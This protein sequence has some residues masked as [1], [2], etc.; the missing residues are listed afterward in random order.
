MT[1]PKPQAGDPEVVKI[2]VGVPGLNAQVPV[3]RSVLSRL[4][5]VFR[6]RSPEHLF[7]MH[8]GLAYVHV[9]EDDDGAIEVYLTV[10]NMGRRTANVEQVHVDGCRANGV[11]LSVMAPVFRPP[12]K[13]I[14]PKGCVESAVT[15]Q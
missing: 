2:V 1:H 14:P 11:N 4:R 9:L 13:P 15:Q 6:R 10:V 5:G 7:V 8:N 3:R 12:D